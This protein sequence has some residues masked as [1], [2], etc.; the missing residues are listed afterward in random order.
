MRGLIV[1]AMFVVSLS[2]ASWNNYHE[3]RN[4]ELDGS[5]LTDVCVN[6]DSGTIEITG[7]QGSVTV[8]DGGPCIVRLE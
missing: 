3:V 5:G 8:D 2:H 7:V 1:M 6:D 4:P